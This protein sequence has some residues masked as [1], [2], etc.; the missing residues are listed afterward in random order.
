MVVGS[1]DEA[2]EREKDRLDHCRCHE[3]SVDPLG[4][5]RLHMWVPNLLNPLR[6]PP[7]QGSARD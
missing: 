1:D 4:F 7:A 6:E 5:I 3:A 2:E